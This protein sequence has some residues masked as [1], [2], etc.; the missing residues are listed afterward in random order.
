[1]S[2]IQRLLLKASLPLIVFMLIALWPQR[3]LLA[4]L[5]FGLLVLV[6]VAFIAMHFIRTLIEAK[7]RLEEEALRPG[8]LHPD[9]RLVRH[10][11]E[12]APQDGWQEQKLTHYYD[13]LA[14][15]TVKHDRKWS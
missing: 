5:L 6:M 4:W 8:R 14:P 7:V 2:D 15:L 9:E 13:G 12:T 3:V 10:E 1:M 11:E